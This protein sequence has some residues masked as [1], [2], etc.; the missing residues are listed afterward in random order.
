[1]NAMDSERQTARTGRAGV[2]FSFIIFWIADFIVRFFRNSTGALGSSLAQSFMMNESNLGTLTSLYFFPYMLMQIPTGYLSDVFGTR[3]V[4]SLGMLAAAAGALIFGTAQNLT[5]LFI[6]RLIIGFGVAAPVVCLQRFITE[7]FD[8]KIQGR[9]SGIESLVGSL[10]SVAAQTPLALLL[11]YLSWR[12]TIAGVG[13]FTLALSVL[14]FFFVKDSG[15]TKLA[16]KM[17]PAVEKTEKKKSPA[18]AFSAI[19]RNKFTWPI[20]AVIFIHMSINAVFSSTYAIPYLSHTF[21][22]SLAEAAQYTTIQAIGQMVGGTI[23]GSLSDKLGRRKIIIVLMSGISLFTWVMFVYGTPLLSIP[24]VMALVMFLNGAVYYQTV[25]LFFASKELNDP[26][27]VGSAVSAA[28]VVGMLGSAAAPNIAAIIMKALINR[29]I[30]DA[31][32]YHA[33]FFWFMAAAAVMF[34]AAFFIRESH[35]RN[36][37]HELVTHLE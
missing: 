17:H 12:M 9:M 28:N 37:Y 16:G 21:G 29:G 22:L 26:L 7:Y 8:E 36:R 6:G 19:Y 33:C 27:Y 30:T 4:L 11:Q 34:F 2:W 25:M 13:V 10:G 14:A 23:F 32:L 20:L 1:M 24:A 15:R 5:T 35:C 18:Q 31:P 3:L